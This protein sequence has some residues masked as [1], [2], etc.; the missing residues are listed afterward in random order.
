MMSEL[1]QVEETKKIEEYNI[2]RSSKKEC[3]N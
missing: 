3:V 2:S 1:L